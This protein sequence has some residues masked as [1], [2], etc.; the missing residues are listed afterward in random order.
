MASRQTGA[1]RTASSTARPVSSN[2][3]R[4]AAASLLSS[5]SRP[6]PGVNQYRWS[7]R[8]GSQPWNNSTRPASSMSNTRAAR[9]EIAV[10]RP[11]PLSVTP[12]RVGQ[13]SARR[14]VGYR[15]EL[16]RYRQPAGPAERPEDHECPPDHRIHR[17][18]RG[19]RVVG[20]LVLLAGIARVE[21]VVA[22]HPQPALGYHDIEHVRARRQVVPTVV[23]EV[24]LVQRLA[25]DLQPVLRVA[26]VHVVAADPDDALDEVGLTRVAAPRFRRIEDDNLAPLRVAE[27]VDEFVH[28]HPVID[29]ERVLHRLRRNVERLQHEGADQDSDDDRNAEEDRKFTPEC[30][31]TL[32]GRLGRLLL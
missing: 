25:V 13:P 12:S 28:Q 1:P 18:G 26:T 31:R 16:P 5:G 14:G 8:A 15:V 23:V 11:S 20:A 6:P 7:G 29:V 9:L 21:P 4:A 30:A 3:S 24:R 22:H 32:L 17:D 27:V 10:A 2:S 19:D